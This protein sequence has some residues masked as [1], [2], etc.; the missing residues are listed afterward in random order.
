MKNIY[1]ILKGIGIEI[2]QDK[3]ESFDKEILENY[4]T[5]AEVEGIRTK[6]TN[7]E[8]E[9]D[10]IKGKYDT[11]IKQRDADLKTLQTQ[12]KDAGVDKGKL[13]ELQNSVTD[14]QKKYTNAKQEYDAQI[15]KQKYEFAVKENVEKLKFS[16]NSAKKAFLSDL[17][18]KEL[19]M[20][21]DKILGFTDF[22]DAYKETDADAFAQETTTEPDVNT[23]STSKPK[24]ADKSNPAN[25]KSKTD[26]GK[27][28][29][30]IIW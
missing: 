23:T 2:P 15:A 29:R 19:K 17:L 5:S 3:K 8:K 7:A 20:E 30:P 9:R 6:L 13:E 16:S 1:E 26:E 11:D 4:K 21:N 22:V 28:E 27:K 25:D 18:S 10:D 24:F 12:L 14:W